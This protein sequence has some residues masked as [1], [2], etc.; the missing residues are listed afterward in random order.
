MAY[1][2][3]DGSELRKKRWMCCQVPISGREENIVCTVAAGPLHLYLYRPVRREARADD[4]V[5]GE[6][7]RTICCC[8]M[9]PVT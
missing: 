6:S 8:A 7:M 3:A 9:L 2:I 5:R 1:Q 4:T